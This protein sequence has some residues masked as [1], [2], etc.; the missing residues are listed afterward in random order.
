MPQL[1]MYEI[2]GATAFCGSACVAVREHPTSQQSDKTT[3]PVKIAVCR[4]ARNA[5]QPTLRSDSGQG[6]R[7]SAIILSPGMFSRWRSA[8]LSKLLHDCLTH[9][10]NS[11][12]RRPG[13]PIFKGERRIGANR[14][15]LRYFYRQLST[16]IAFDECRFVPVSLLSP[17]I[18]AHQGE[19]AGL[20]FWIP[21]AH[22]KILRL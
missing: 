21:A 6:P 9:H 10:V 12:L 5:R 19:I 18:H 17:G 22:E 2:A 3:A 15:W 11:L 14:L 8:I 4:R 7:P 13:V 16:Q 20:T 1:A